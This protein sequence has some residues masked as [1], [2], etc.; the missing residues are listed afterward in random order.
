MFQSIGSIAAEIRCHRRSLRE[1]EEMGESG[2]VTCEQVRDRLLDAE[3]R[4]V[5][6]CSDRLDDGGYDL[7]FETMLDRVCSE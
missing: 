2:S 4:L 1:S 3:Y 5:G 6:R 7:W